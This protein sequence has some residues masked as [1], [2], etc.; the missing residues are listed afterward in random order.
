MNDLAQVPSRGFRERS[1]TLLDVGRILT[2][3]LQPGELYRAIH[4]QADRVLDADDFYIAL[5]DESGDTA[6]IVFYAHAARE[7]SVKIAYRGSLS[8]SIREARAAF[9]SRTDPELATL[10]LALGA[11]AG[12]ICGVSAPIMADGR[13]VGVLGAL[14]E[15]DNAFTE[16]DLDVVSALGALAGVA[17]GSAQ[18]IRE[19][20]QRRLQAER[21]EE[22][23]RGLAA[24]LELPEVLERVVVAAC[25]L[26]EADAAAVMLRDRSNGMRIAASR[27]SA[28]VESGQPVPIAGA[29][30]DRLLSERRG[31]A[32]ENLVGTPVL[33]PAIANVE[34]S[35]ALAVPLVAGDQV[36]GILSIAHARP[37]EYN[38]METSLL[39][40]LAVNVAIAV[41]NA[42]LH[43]QIR[44]LS[45]T[46]PLT[47]LPNRR[48]LERVL[49]R[50]FAA[51]QRGRRLAVVLFDLDHFKRYNDTA[52]HQAG[53]QALRAFAGVLAAETRAFDLAARY[54]GDE[55]LCILSDANP[56][57]AESHTRRVQRSVAEHPLLV[58]IGASAGTAWYNPSMHS[59]EDLI[60]AADQELYRNKR[61]RD[62]A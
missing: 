16:R 8:T 20:D 40:R 25:E 30:R 10:R 58:R 4:E 9:L 61:R 5:F 60:R 54:G 12:A 45:L 36:I 29:L 15:R 43:E 46:D 19:T 21:L 3:A 24:S 51:A 23:G 59:P 33:P 2:G 1:T 50:E 53:D 17:L 18:Y 27:G 28:G 39:E 22:I 13:V 52:G 56:G 44:A 32:I 26:L 35:S 49:E 14:S 34:S 47:G 42:R 11:E 57:G 38:G 31:V 55:F 37:R 62:N 6:T 48:H 41:E 7:A